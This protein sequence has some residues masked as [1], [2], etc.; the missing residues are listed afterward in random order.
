[1]KNKSLIF[2]TLAATILVTGCSQSNPSAENSAAS[3]TNSL[4]VTQQ[5]QNAK[6][7]ATNA[8]EKTKEA[9]TNAWADLTEA[10]QPGTD[11]SY[12]KKDAFVAAASA[13]LA[14]LDQKIDG[15]SEKIANASDSVKA[16]AQTKLQ[17]LRNKRVNLDAKLA[18][19]K[20]STEATWNDTK[21]GFQNAYDDTKSYLKQSWQSLTSN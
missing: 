18:E 17:E 6:E 14:T 16:D 1:M 13:D 21:T 2:A 8:W 4:S 3:D 7:M 5:L 19:V 12:D 9:T 15:L 11:Y 10:L 20:N